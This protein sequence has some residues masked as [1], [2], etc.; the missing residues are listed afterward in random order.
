MLVNFQNNDN[1]VILDNE[2]FGYWDVEVLRPAKND[3]G[4][5]VMVKGKVKYVKDK[6]SFQ[7]PYNYEGGI[8]RFF[9]KEVQQRDPEA[10]LGK[11]TLGYEIRFA[12]Y[13]SRKVDAKET[14]DLQV[15][16]GSMQR[17]YCLC[18]QNCQIGSEQTI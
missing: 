15:K 17:R 13:F 7:I 2:E 1:S 3:K 12:N 9:E 11:A 6:Y 16:I 4:E 10:I 14:K 18:S 5:T 8:E